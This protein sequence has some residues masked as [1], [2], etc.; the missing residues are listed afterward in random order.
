MFR[1]RPERLDC[2]ALAQG[3]GGDPRVGGCVTFAG[4]VRNH[5]N[6]RAV[7][8]LEYEAYEV[9]AVAEGRRIVE[10]ALEKFDVLC[11]ECEH[12]VGLLEIGETAVWVGAAAAHRRAAFEACQYVIDELKVR[13]PIW[14]KEYYT[15]GGAEWVLC[16]HCSAAGPHSHPEHVHSA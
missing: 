10:E 2:S 3:L 8:R 14:K 4:V 16:A 6:G 7:E 9:L 12:R 5:N 15:D 1:L 13:V 11:V